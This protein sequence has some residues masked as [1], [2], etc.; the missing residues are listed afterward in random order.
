MLTRSQLHSYNPNKLRRAA[1]VTSEKQIRLN[2]EAHFHE[3]QA[4]KVRS[5]WPGTTGESA[6]AKLLDQVKELREQADVLARM[7]RLMSECADKVEQAKAELTQLDLVVRGRRLQVD[8]YGV[9][10]L[11]PLSYLEEPRVVAEL[12]SHAARLTHQYYDLLTRTDAMLKHTAALLYENAKLPSPYDILPD[13]GP[14][15]LTDADI[16]LQ[17][18]TSMQGE[19]S[20]CFFLSGLAGVAHA[21]PEF[22]RKSLRWDPESQTYKVTVYMSTPLGAV[23]REVSV[24][25]YELERNIDKLDDEG[26]RPVLGPDRRINFLSIYEAA[27]RK[28]LDGTILTNTGG[29]P[30]WGMSTFTG[31]DPD[32]TLLTPHSFAEIRR[33]MEGKPPGAVSAGTNPGIWPYPDPAEQPYEK[34]IVPRHAYWVKG[35]DD[36][37]R[38]I[39][40]NP[41]G[42]GGGVWGNDGLDYPGEVHLTEEEFR[43]VFTQTARM[44]P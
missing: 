2:S 10:A 1:A 8:D 15:R 7:A 37:G 36:K 28:T 26:E 27:Y 13:T 6:A 11:I 14:V 34:R 39:L 44:V 22:I 43:E 4:G 21:D 24:D 33:T 32:S 9:V 42:P 29:L 38:I 17:A 19:H 25:P 3:K 31:K 20:D 41:W 16:R 23:P 18:E 40:V 12:R 5:S 30:S 35:F